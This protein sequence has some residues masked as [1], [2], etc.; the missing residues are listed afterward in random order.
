MPNA[1]R[2]CNSPRA[3]RLH[4]DNPIFITKRERIGPKQR[5]NGVCQP[6]R[7]PRPGTQ[8]PATQRN[9]GAI[10]AIFGR[11]FKRLPSVRPHAQSQS[12]A[13]WLAWTGHRRS[14]RVPLPEGACRLN[15]TA[16]PPSSG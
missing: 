10:R 5:R 8:G 3:I 6:L 2:E 4:A 16:K 13:P 12:K 7:P 9:A 15:F 11:A 1:D 14:G